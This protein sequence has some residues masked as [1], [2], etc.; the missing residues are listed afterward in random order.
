MLPLRKRLTVLFRGCPRQDLIGQIRL[1]GP[2][3]GR[4]ILA[5]TN[6]GLLAVSIENRFASN[7]K[8]IVG[9]CCLRIPASIA[10]W[11]LSDLF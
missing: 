1:A 2:S 6:G 4:W 3:L 8:P 7:G 10:F 11:H 9:G 5:D